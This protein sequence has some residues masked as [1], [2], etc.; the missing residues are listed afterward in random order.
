MQSVALKQTDKIHPHKFAMWIA[1]G[2]IVMM[3][4]GLTSAVIIKK[5]QAG[6][7][8]VEIPTV[9]YI[10]TLVMLCSSFLL[11]RA[12]KAF[13]NRDMVRYRIL[14][15]ATLSLGILFVVLQI[16]GFNQYW[17]DGLRLNSSP[18]SYQLLYV[19]V[20]LHALHVIGGVVALVVMV[21]RS[22]SLTK[23]Y[24]SNVPL[25]VTSTYWHFVDV[26]W[27]YLLLFLILVNR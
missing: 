20:G 17:N 9:F 10:S 24:Y 3:F 2:S 11:H 23:K 19:I 12:D 8:P 15:T 16:V 25:Q 5:S 6:W 7:N 18:V 4:A 22:F 13:V 21:L 26:L 27:I 14:M 1:I